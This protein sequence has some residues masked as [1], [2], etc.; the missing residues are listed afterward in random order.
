MTSSGSPGRVLRGRVK[1][2]S[3]PG[4]WTSLVTYATLPIW[5]QIN[6]D[7]LS[8]NRRR[9]SQNIVPI[10]RLIIALTILLVSGGKPYA[11]S[12]IDWKERA[13]EF[14]RLA[15]DE[16]AS[17]SHLPLLKWRDGEKPGSEPLVCGAAR[18]AVGTAGYAVPGR[19]G[20]EY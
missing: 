17:G 13:L 18:G 1:I 10:R 8:A 19:R 11:Q 5:E 7:E 20:A 2:K 14:D 3:N 4:E 6:G 15:F 16:T 12:V 9:P